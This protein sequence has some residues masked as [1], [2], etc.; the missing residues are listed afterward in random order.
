MSHPDPKL[1]IGQIVKLPGMKFRTLVHK[2]T[3]IVNNEFV[4]NELFVFSENEI[5]SILYSNGL[6][7]K[8]AV[9]P[10]PAEPVDAA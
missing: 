10:A 5:H 7:A 1:L 6:V 9:E 2:L 3:A 8:P 4:L